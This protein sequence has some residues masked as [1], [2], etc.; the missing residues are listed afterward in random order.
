MIKKQKS[1]TVYDNELTGTNKYSN[2]LVVIKS[3]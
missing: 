2:Q 1:G 3:K